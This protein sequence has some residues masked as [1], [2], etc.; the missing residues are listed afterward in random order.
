[1]GILSQIYYV[2]PRDPSEDYVPQEGP[3][4]KPFTKDIGDALVREAPTSPKGSVM[5]LLCRP[6]ELTPQGKIYKFN[7]VKIKNSR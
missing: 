2:R 6:E 5:I 3:E 1:M 7:Y 4:A